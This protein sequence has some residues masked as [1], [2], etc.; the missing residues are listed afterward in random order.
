MGRMKENLTIIIVTHNRPALIARAL[1]YYMKWNCTI[2]V[3]DSSCDLPKFVDSPKIQV[4]HTPGLLYNQKIHEALKKVITPYV[5]LSADDDFLAE[6]GIMMSIG[7]LEEHKDYVSAQG[8]YVMFNWVLRQVLIYPNYLSTIGYNI[9]ADYSAQRMKTYMHQIYSLHRTNVF[10]KSFLMMSD[11]DIN[12]LVELG[13]AINGMIYGKH[14]VL[15]VFWMA[16][17]SCRYTIY[18]DST[19][20][21]NTFTSVS[22]GLAKLDGLHYQ[23]RFSREYSSHTGESLDKGREVFSQAFSEYLGNRPNSKINKKLHHQMKKFIPE[24][25]LQLYRLSFGKLMKSWRYSNFPGYP[26]GDSI[27]RKDWDSMKKIIVKHGEIP[28]KRDPNP[29]PLSQV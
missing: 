27:A 12:E 10:Q 14:M 21:A 24:L 5:C 13:V 11:L 28:A 19:D 15:P 26:F 20:R 7:F 18:T 16:R 6:S 4:L 25:F 2:F 1:D 29:Y 22:A 9:D 17:D 3:C 8:H 23:D